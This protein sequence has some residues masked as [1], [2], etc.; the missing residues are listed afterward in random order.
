[1]YRFRVVCHVKVPGGMPCTGAAVGDPAAAAAAPKDLA[2][3]HLAYAAAATRSEAAVHALPIVEFITISVFKKVQPLNRVVIRM[4]VKTMRQMNHLPD[5]Y[6]YSYTQYVSAVSTVY[7][8]WCVA[9]REL[10]G[11]PST[12]WGRGRGSV[13]P[14]KPPCFFYSTA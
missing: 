8:L 5:R 14:L 10:S 4:L 13:P 3:Q 1:M 11:T 12:P 2:P 9:G 6:R 7:V